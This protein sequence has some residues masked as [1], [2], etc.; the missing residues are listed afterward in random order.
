MLAQS[1]KCTKY[2][3]REKLHGFHYMLNPL[4]VRVYYIMLLQSHARIQKTLAHQSVLLFYSPKSSNT[5]LCLPRWRNG[6]LENGSSY[7]TPYNQKGGQFRIFDCL[8]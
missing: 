4:N 6:N 3:T 5:E 7:D 8:S 2:E 1:Q